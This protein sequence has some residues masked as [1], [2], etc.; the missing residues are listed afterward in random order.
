LSRIMFRLLLVC[1][2]SLALL[3][4]S[5]S[6]TS[7]Q[8]FPPPTGFVSDYAGVFSDDVKAQ[9]E[10]L[11]RQFEQE[12]TVEVVVVTVP[13]LQG[14]SIEAYSVS[15]FE[16]W[17]IGKKGV[18]NGVL[19]LLATQ[20]RKVRIEV[21][22]GM[23]P[24]LTDGQV[25]RIL[26]NEVIPDLKAGNFSLGLLKGARGIVQ[27]IKASD[28]QPGTVRARPLVNPLIESIQRNLWLVIGLGAVSVYL[29]A[30]MARSKSIALGGIWGAGSG[31]LLGWV[32]YGLI[33]LVVGAI[34][35]GLV[36]L[37]L[38]ALLSSAY[39]FQASSGRPTGWR[40]TWGGF[41][42]GSPPG[43]SGGRGFG[44]FGGGR[45]GGGGASRGF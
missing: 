15:L 3:V 43:W 1:C 40:Q 29:M 42:G 17:G 18:D 38:D 21:G 11:L 6:H 27:A 35:L 12:S 16:K 28:Y 8:E 14:E 26:D 7:A 31:V 13:D 32:S 33:G 2:L 45:S 4:A 24:Y 41:S 22:Y 10:G 5:A 39:R 44:G 19:L 23:E 25:G 36:G 9:L 37:L 30:Y 20:D 34:G